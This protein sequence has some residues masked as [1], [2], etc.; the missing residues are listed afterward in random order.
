MLSSLLPWE[1][2][3]SHRACGHLS[4]CPSPLSIP[5]SEMLGHFLLDFV[6]WFSKGI[7]FSMLFRS[8]I[9]LWGKK[10]KKHL[11]KPERAKL[12]SQLRKWIQPPTHSI[13]RH[14][15]IHT[16]ES[17]YGCPKPWE[18]LSCAWLATS[19]LLLGVKSRCWANQ[20]LTRACAVEPGIGSCAY[21]C[22]CEHPCTQRCP[23]LHP[24][25][26]SNRS[27]DRSSSTCPMGSGCPPCLGAGRVAGPISQADDT[28]Q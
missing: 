14:Q 8:L 25:V 4:V 1:G 23:S 3:V 11:G 26:P 20:V 19:E 15:R 10:K 21:W 24:E 6:A 13:I 28:E 27:S 18:K 5:V 22:H 2:G 9:V 17:H 16:G 7:H 12:W